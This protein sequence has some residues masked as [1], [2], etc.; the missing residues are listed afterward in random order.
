MPLVVVPFRDDSGAR[1]VYLRAGHVSAQVLDPAVGFVNDLAREASHVVCFEHRDLDDICSTPKTVYDVR[2]LYGGERKLLDLAREHLDVVSYSDL[3]EQERRFEVQLKV[4]RATQVDTGHHSLLRIIPPEAIRRLFAAR[5]TATMALFEKALRGETCDLGAYERELWPFACALRQVE[6]NGI[7]VDVGYAR[8][9]LLRTDLPKHERKFF[10]HMVHQSRDRYVRTTFNPCG[11]STGRVK[12]DSGFN[13]LGIPHGD[14]RRAI[15]SRFDG[16][17]ILDF[18]Y[19]A[20]DYRSIVSSVE[21]PGFRR[22]YEGCAD[23]HSRTCEM[24]LQNLYH[25][26]VEPSALQRDIVKY[27]SYVYIYGGSDETLQSKT[28]LSLEKIRQVKEAMDRRLYPIAEFR[29][30]LGRRARREGFV[31]L[32]NGRRIPVASDDHDGKII[33]LYAQGFSAWV[34]QQALV[35]VTGYMKDKQSRV[36]FTV[37]DSLVV[38]HANEPEVVLAVQSLMETATEGRDFRVNVKRGRTYEDA[39]AK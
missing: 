12:V 28:H 37:H 2:L 38:D 34:F 24:I 11:T 10:E 7:R 30:E 29:R 22:L 15:V 18:D 17:E 16:G 8:A 9:S 6:L 31:L 13:V 14:V 20:I 19:N 3:L 1:A 32:P 21:D 39:T 25:R 4:C 26:K 5:A 36:L 35:R 33:G 27:F 23:F